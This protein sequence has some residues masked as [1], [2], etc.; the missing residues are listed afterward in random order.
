MCVCVQMEREYVRPYQNINNLWDRATFEAKRLVN[1][2]SGHGFK[3][4]DTDQYVSNL[5]TVAQ[6][7][8]HSVESLSSEE[9]SALDEKIAEAKRLLDNFLNPPE[10]E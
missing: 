9:L 10:L 4:H 8:G 2:V 6:V 5:L 3:M 1:I 7:L